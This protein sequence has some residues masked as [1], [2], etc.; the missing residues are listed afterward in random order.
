MRVSTQTAGAEVCEAPRAGFKAR[1][2]KAPPNVQSLISGAEIRAPNP[3]WTIG[4]AVVGSGVLPR[5]AH[6]PRPRADLLAPPL[7]PQF[8][9][10]G[11]V[12][13]L[14]IRD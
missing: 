8:H 1:H 3:R 14:N 13:S 12:M 2:L 5:P 7:S 9:P 10:D 6:R 11:R 4:M